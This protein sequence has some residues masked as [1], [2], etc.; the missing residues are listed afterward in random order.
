MPKI[1]G[2]M[3]DGGD[4]KA[5]ER[6][7]GENGRVSNKGFVEILKISS[8]NASWRVLCKVCIIFVK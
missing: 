6:K 3:G 5:R 4:E 2:G 7:E 8:H 1:C